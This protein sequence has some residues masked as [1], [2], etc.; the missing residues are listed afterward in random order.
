MAG[1]KESDPSLLTVVDRGRGSRPTGEPERPASVP[2]ERY[3]LGR[4]IARGGMGRVV[5]AF[6]TK[7]G[8]TVALKEALADTDD[9]LRRFRREI[10]ITARL[11]H[12]SIVPVHDAGESANGSPFYVMRKVSGRPLEELVLAADTL[13]KRLALLPNLVATAN[14]IAHAHRRGVIHRDI[15]PTNI[16]IGD[17]GETVVIDWGLAKVTGE[18]DDDDDLGAASPLAAGDSLRTR[19]GTVFGTPGFMP[20]EQ[21]RG[22]PV[23]AGSDVY[24]L[25]ATLYYTLAR[26][27]PHAAASGDETLVA[28]E[29]GPPEPLSMLVAGV[30]PELATIVDKALA[31]DPRVRYRDAGALAE[32]LGSF[33]S[34]QLVGAHRYSRRERLMRFV[35]RYRAAFAIAGLAII[36]LAIGSWIAIGR[37]LDERDRADAEAAL[38]TRRE[39][40]AEL[41]RAAEQDRADQLLI[42]QAQQLARTNGSAAIA[43]IRQLAEQ[44]ARWQKWWRQARA[45]AAEANVSGVAWGYVGPQLAASLV[46]SPSGTRAAAI[47]LNGDLWWYDLATHRA[48]E[49]GQ[50]L[51]RNAIFAGDDQ[52][53]V[54]NDDRATIVKLL[55]RTTVE[56]TTPEAIKSLDATEQFVWWTSDRALWRLD[57][58]TGKSD[59]IS[60]VS[61]TLSTAISPDGRHV[62]VVEK[63]GLWVAE[64]D[65]TVPPRLLVAGELGLPAWAPDSERISISAE[66]K[67]AVV[68]L[69]NPNAPIKWV[70]I[71]SRFNVPQYTSTGA[72]Y[73]AGQNGVV[74]VLGERLIPRLTEAVD[75]MRIIATYNGNIVVA[76]GNL[77]RIVG[78]S[79]TI[80]VQLPAEQLDRL[81]ARPNSPYVVASSNGRVFAYDLTPMFPHIAR[82]EGFMSTSS[83]GDHDFIG[84]SG[85]GWAWL[86]VDTSKL[87]AIDID[88]IAP[89]GVAGQSSVGDAGFILSFDGR[90]WT[91]HKGDRHAT[92]VDTSVRYAVM[93][94]DSMTY[95]KTDGTIVSYSLRD[96]RKTTLATKHGTVFALAQRNESVVAAMYADGTVWRLDR[97]TNVAS[98]LTLD[99]LS[100]N[101]Q[102]ELDQ[103]DAL[104]IPNGPRAIRW[105]AA[106]KV[107]TIATLPARVMSVSP[108]DAGTK[109][110][111]GATDGAAYLVPADGSAPPVAVIPSGTE[112]IGTS[113]SRGIAAF[114]TSR[115]I[116]LVD[117][118]SG[119]RWPFIPGDRQLRAQSVRISRDGKKIAAT[120]DGTLIVLDLELPM[121]AAETRAWLDQLTN[122]SADLGASALTW[123]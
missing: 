18:P 3:E 79:H 110:L 26:K 22:E 104:L 66:S 107:T 50:F 25:G 15:K 47:G 67:N 97:T 7:L 91:V 41:A 57:L 93:D 80:G 53:F 27:P 10:R 117:M 116:D 46:M 92:A 30:P 111:I 54:F 34:G 32:D 123:R 63:R 61:R 43:M 9:A 37:V 28:A 21:I 94:I 16:L 62:L 5:D 77:L 76:N 86:D 122:A 89:M 83:A 49:L 40:D 23:G 112:D 105:D 35:R 98:T 119:A 33:L 85:N 44:P 13:G 51:H 36:A 81:I 39:Q 115:G 24:A 1:P 14:A 64:V 68:S 113:L 96:G 17:L 4:E 78:S 55:D 11:E 59:R 48:V 103:Q 73:L 70:A 84:N 108:L 2:P 106:G 88:Q 82:F 29:R 56:L 8:R 65:A 12:P 90:L 118:A 120:I 72:L 19:I 109:L 52:L 75:N 121:T 60:D 69:A 42:Y 58:A 95:A 74:A 100:D 101:S 38:A 71:Q 102:L 87:T 114:P 20:P 31:Y 6:D 45:V 99:S